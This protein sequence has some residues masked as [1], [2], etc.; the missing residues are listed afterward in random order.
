ML[1]GKRG[2]KK[3]Q[4]ETEEPLLQGDEGSQDMESYLPAATVTNL[5]QTRGLKITHMYDLNVYS[6]GPLLP[7]S[8]CNSPKTVPGSSLLLGLLPSCLPLR[9]SL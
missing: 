7:S 6:R 9:R 5:P 3:P 1:R 8:K 4:K 2:A